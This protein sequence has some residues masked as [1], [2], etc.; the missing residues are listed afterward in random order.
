MGALFGMADTKKG[1]RISKS[2]AK[3]SDAPRRLQPALRWAVD[4]LCHKQ[5]ESRYTLVVLALPSLTDIAIAFSDLR[6]KLTT[7]PEVFRRYAT[8][9]DT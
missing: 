1:K 5:D 9:M 2:Q 6:A 7:T 3:R 4:K 8:G